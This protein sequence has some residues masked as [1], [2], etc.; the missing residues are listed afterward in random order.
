MRPKATVFSSI[1]DNRPDEPDAACV[2]V[3]YK[4]KA[5]VGGAIVVPTVAQ[6]LLDERPI[7]PVQ[8]NG[9]PPLEMDNVIVYV[10]EMVQYVGS[11]RTESA[12]IVT[13]TSQRHR[14]ENRLPGA[15]GVVDVGAPKALLLVMEATVGPLPMEIN[16]TGDE[17]VVAH[18]IALLHSE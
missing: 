4:A 5:N 16:G 12:S 8:A 10:P 1:L 3:S 6:T 18:V 15:I 17:P 13:G 2:D 9:A 14:P 7:V 11:D